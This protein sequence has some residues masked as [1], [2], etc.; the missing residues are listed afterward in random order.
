MRVRTDLQEFTRGQN[1]MGKKEGGAN[2]GFGALV[3]GEVQLGLDLWREAVAI[4][5]VQ[6]AVKRCHAPQNGQTAGGSS[7]NVKAVGGKQSSKE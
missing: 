6:L 4:A 2:H 1:R 3:V 5:I 7:A